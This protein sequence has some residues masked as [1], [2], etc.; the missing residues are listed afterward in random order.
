MGAEE[1]EVDFKEISE[2]EALSILKV[3]RLGTDAAPGGGAC[4]LHVAGPWPLA[5]GP[6]CNTMHACM[7]TFLPCA[8]HHLAASVL[9]WAGRGGSLGDDLRLVGAAPARAPGPIPRSGAHPLALPGVLPCGLAMRESL[10]RAQAGPPCAASSHAMHC[11]CMCMQASMHVS[12]RVGCTCAR[13][14]GIPFSRDLAHPGAPLKNAAR[15]CAFLGLAAP[16]MR[17]SQGCRAQSA[18]LPAGATSAP[19]A[20]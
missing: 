1:K 17:P 7:P 6:F 12:P 3:H 5:A 19:A 9:L 16:R 10:S 14:P 2:A 8:L 13:M 20:V 18:S 15:A 11:S 4:G